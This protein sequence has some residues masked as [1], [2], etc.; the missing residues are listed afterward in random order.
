M[1]NKPGKTKKNYLLEK[2]KKSICCSMQ[3]VLH[4]FLCLT[5]CITCFVTA[6]GAEYGAVF[7]L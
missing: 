5:G 4:V 2:Q 3:F 1:I 7:F 6:C